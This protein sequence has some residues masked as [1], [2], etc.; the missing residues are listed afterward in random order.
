MKPLILEAVIKQRV[1]ISG[2]TS[3]SHLTTTAHGITSVIFIMSLLACSSTLMIW[4]LR[5]LSRLHIRSCGPQQSAMFLF[6]KA[7]SHTWRALTT[8]ARLIR[9][10]TS[11]F[12][13]TTL[14]SAAK[15][16]PL[17]L[18]RLGRMG[19]G[20]VTLRV[21]CALLRVIHLLL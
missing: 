9:P 7:E 21:L 17:L 12:V 20:F 6:Y 19:S 5:S 2:R 10:W 3:I 15:D 16:L 11:R 14:A 4:V 1:I 13:Q 8:R 18:C